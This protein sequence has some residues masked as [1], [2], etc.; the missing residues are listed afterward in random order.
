MQACSAAI[1]PASIKQEGESP[2]V[3]AEKTSPV[4]CLQAASLNQRSTRLL[5][6]LNCGTNAL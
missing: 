5:I 6:Y 3:K 2:A 1:N 4:S